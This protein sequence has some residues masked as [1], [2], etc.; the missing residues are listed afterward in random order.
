R[1]IPVVKNGQI[2]IGNEM[3]VTLSVD[4]RIIDGIMSGNFLAAFKQALEM[5]ALLV[6]QA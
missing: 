3:T 1:E 6:M 2:T 4:H 5:P